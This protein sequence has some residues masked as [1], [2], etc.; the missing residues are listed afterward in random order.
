MPF[1]VLTAA[2]LPAY[3]ATLPPMQERFTDFEALDVAEV[4]D[5]NVNFVFLV[6][7][8]G[9][10]ERTVCVKQAVPY[11]RC[12][13][14]SWPLTRHRMDVE[15]RALREFGALCPQHV[16]AVYA[17]DSEMSL[18]VMQRLC[19]HRILRL[20]LIDGLVYP[21]MSDHISTYLARTLF[22]TSD[23]YLA[24][25]A[26]K[27]AVAG[28]S[29]PELC[30]ITEDLVFTHPYD[31]SPTNAYPP[32]L[33]PRA[34][35]RLQRNPPL[36][37]AVGEMKYA[38]MTATEARL[39]GDL[40]TGSVMAN[41]E[42]TFV[43]DPE[44]SFY[45]PMG[46]DVGAFIANLFLAYVAQEHRQRDAGRDPAPYREWLLQSAVETWEGFE[47]KFLALWREHEA[48]GTG[49]IGRDLDGESAEVFR[50]AFMRH[51]FADTLGFAACKMMRRIVGLAKVADIAGITD[52]AARTLAEVRALRIA[53]HLILS[54]HAFGSIGAVVAA[55]ERLGATPLDA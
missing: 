13:G 43:I 50:A 16:P 26:K 45:G 17:A 29:N 36:R 49:F 33:P 14:E 12:V 38:F 52:V 4:G 44:F 18:V 42:E 32:G 54:R 6:T 35:E 3:L 9:A 55:V 23:L 28:A 22:F 34:I 27:A 15:V 1:Q 20:G 53:E 31:D 8:R 46:F 41:A 7:Q 51:V 24:P 19:N 21:R 40:H 39:H 37:A 2:A 47:R 5:G 10:P 11:L 48:D 30:R 25:D